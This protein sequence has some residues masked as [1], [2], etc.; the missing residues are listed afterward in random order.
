MKKSFRFAFFSF[1]EL[2]G[3]EPNSLLN[4]RNKTK[5]GKRVFIS[6]RDEYTIIRHINQ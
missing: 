4:Q 6:K 5:K 2:F 3:F 1:T